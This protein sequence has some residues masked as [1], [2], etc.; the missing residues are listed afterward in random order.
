[1]HVIGIDANMYYDAAG[2]DAVAWTELTNVRDVALELEKGEADVSNRAYG[3][4]RAIVGTLKDATV[5]WDM[6]Y[7]TDD[8]GFIAIR[9]AWFSDTTPFGLAIMDGPIATPGSEGLKIDVEILAFGIPQP[10][11]DAF[12]VNVRAKP[13]YSSTDPAWYTAS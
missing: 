7:D 12:K 11:E 8:A 4:W 6:I 1:M 9:G 13:T 10:M 3:G 5:T 2:V